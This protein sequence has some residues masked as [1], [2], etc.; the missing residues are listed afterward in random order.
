MTCLAFE[1]PSQR[2]TSVFFFCFLGG[3]GSAFSSCF[4]GM[5][6]VM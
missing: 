2:S 3:V 4:Y 1:W 5:G 6:N